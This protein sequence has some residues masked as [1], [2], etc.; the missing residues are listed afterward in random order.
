MVDARPHR[1]TCRGSATESLSRQVSRRRTSVA[2]ACH[3]C[4]PPR[5]RSGQVERHV[6]IDRGASGRDVERGE[7][8]RQ[9]LSHIGPQGQA[10]LV[11]AAGDLVSLRVEGEVPDVGD[12]LRLRTQLDGRR[13]ALLEE[14]RPLCLERLRRFLE[15]D[16]GRDGGCGRACAG[17]GGDRG[18][19]ASG[20]D[21]GAAL[22]S[23]GKGGP[24]GRRSRRP[25][26]I[27]TPMR[28]PA[29]MMAAGVKRFRSATDQLVTWTQP[30]T[31]S[32]LLI[33]MAPP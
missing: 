4:A 23:I 6:D 9:A 19:E 25:K 8:A 5:S 2:H 30:F 22:E 14:R 17:C 24:S 10:V 31:K 3:G 27:P 12:G 32:L 21:A 20:R 18:D 11:E 33:A 15:G 1:G 28:A 16:A 13:P 29:T 7:H 26:N